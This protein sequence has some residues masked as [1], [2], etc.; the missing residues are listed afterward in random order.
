MVDIIGFTNGCFDILHIGHINLI[1][2]L[3]NK[4]DLVI[5]GIDSDKRVK[6]S[7]GSDR[8]FNSQQDRKLML[9]SLRFVDRVH[10]FDSEQELSNLVQLIQPDIMIVGSDY[11][12][13]KVI[14]SEHAKRLEFFEKIDGYS[15]TK[16][17]QYTS[18]RR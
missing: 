18:H 16:I 8:P 13:K 3:K 7:K 9:E 15:T 10:I 14:G 5:I 12:N 1:K 2:H 6:Q 17:L 4:C 11:K